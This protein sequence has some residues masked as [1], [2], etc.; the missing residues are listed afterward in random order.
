MT[1]LDIHAV[2]R[3]ALRTTE[4]GELAVVCNESEARADALYRRIVELTGETSL[5]EVLQVTTTLNYASDATK[6]ERLFLELPEGVNPDSVGDLQPIPGGETAEGPYEAYA[7]PARDITEVGVEV[8]GGLLVSYYEFGQEPER[9]SLVV[10]LE[11]SKISPVI[12]GLLDSLR[13]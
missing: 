2:T 3:Q 9:N 11:P 8:P 4:R 6:T 10:R 12:A 1:K 5:K 13:S 7:T